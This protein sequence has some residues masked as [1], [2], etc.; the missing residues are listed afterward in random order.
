MKL[1]RILSTI[2]VLALS[3]ALLSACGKTT[4]TSDSQEE[5][6]SADES[7]SEDTEELSY[8]E[9]SDEELQ[10]LYEKEEG[11]SRTIHIGYDGGLCQAAIPVAQYEGFFEEEGL[12]TELT[13]AED[14]RDALAAELIDTSAGMIAGWLTSVQNGVDIRFVVGL[15]TG[16]AAA[17]T[18]PDS[19]ITGFEPGQKIGVVGN[20]GGIY[21][22]IGL[23]MAAHD[24]FSADDFTWLGFDSSAI[25]L[26]LQDH[27]V[28]VIVVSEQLSQQWLNE[29]SVKQIRSLTTDDDFKD[30]ACCVM[31][32]SGKFYDE[33]PVTSYK[34]TRAVY[35]A[36]LWLAESE[37]NRAEAAKILVDN[38]YVACS[39]EYA[40]QL[41]NYYQFGLDNATTEKSLYDS[42]DEYIQLGVLSAEADAEAFKA[43]IWQPFDLDDLAK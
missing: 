5:S 2:L 19:D 15:H 38:G 35:R 3:A 27:E 23:R 33:N 14:A 40:L 25:L 43:Q 24:G 42:V 16:C 11:S 22:N 21:H 41:L 37:E 30:E 28:D 12:D 7:A 10:A 32:I 29:G 1:K 18:L 4:T 17:V 39:E 8:A 9:L 20:I 34:I 26:A 36:S 13:A 31:G 6:T